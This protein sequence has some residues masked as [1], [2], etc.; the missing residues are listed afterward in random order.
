MRILNL[1][2][3]AG[4]L[5]GGVAHAQC[6]D[7]DKAAL[8]KFDREWGAAGQKGDKAALDAIYSESFAE[9]APGNHA[10]R[11]AAIS[12]TLETAGDAPPVTHDFYMIGCSKN[13]AL[14]THRNSVT[15]GE[16]DDARTFQ[17]R[18]V[19]QLEKQGSA[20]KVVGNATHP[21]DESMQV[22]YMDLE[23]NIA[24]LAGDR[25]WFERTLADDYL[26]VGSRDGKFENKRE[27]LADFG[28]Y[29]ATT[30]VTTDLD[31]QVDGK[32]ARVSGIYHSTGTDEKGAAY[33]R[34]TAFIDVWV[35]RDGQWRIWSS[36]G[37]EVKD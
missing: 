7:A 20:W 15:V 26:G 35:K 18:S 9:L 12:D 3:L 30:A 31:V 16:G 4:L 27:F 19:H 10:D 6:S 2:I 14:I 13:S 21:L 5:S 17:T 29:K 11:A 36:Q 25:G 28:K 8:E 37:T 23:W 33:D 1:A 22:G 34:H 32:T 24:E